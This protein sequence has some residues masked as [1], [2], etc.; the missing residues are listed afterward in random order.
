M[1]RVRIWWIV[2]YP[3]WA[4]QLVA[5]TVCSQLRHEYAGICRSVEYL[6]V[7]LVDVMLVDRVSAM[8]CNILCKSMTGRTC[9]DSVHDI[10]A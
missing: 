6:L 2:I 3:E 4:C 1:S 5:G 9:G 8:C 10:A 7:K